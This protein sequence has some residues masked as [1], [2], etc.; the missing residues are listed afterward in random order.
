MKSIQFIIYDDPVPQ[1]R[2]RFAAKG[3]DG[4]P[5]PFVKVYDPKT[6]KD[7]KATVKTRAI[8]CGH[9]ELLPGALRMI[10]I[11]RFKR[12]KSHYGKKGILPS[13]PKYH[14]VK[15]D[16]DNL[17]KAI[18]DALEGT[19]YKGDQQIC[20]VKKK[21]EYADDGFVPGVIVRIEVINP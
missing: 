6:S 16:L 2:P 5:L 12:P 19:C 7:W 11:F 8:E 20:D 17:E 13:A 4:K 21:K 15:P 14:I 1:G 18:K 9:N 3:K 10:L